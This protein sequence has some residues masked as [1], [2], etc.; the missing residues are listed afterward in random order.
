MATR[1][2][3]VVA[4]DDPV[5]AR[6]Y[7]EA[8][9]HEID[10]LHRKLTRFSPD[11]L[12]SHINR[13]AATRPVK[14]DTEIFALLESA[15]AVKAQS[16]GAFDIALGSGDII[17]DRAARTVAFERPDVSLD[18]GG[19]AKGFAL[20]RAAAI[21]REGGFDRAL[22][23]GGTSSVLA[24]GAPPDAAGWRVAL[25]RSRALPWTELT[26]QALSVSRPFAQL[27]DGGAHIIDPRSR[28]RVLQRR[29]AVAIGPSAAL[30][31]AWSTAISVLGDR[32]PTLGTEWTTSI[33]HEDE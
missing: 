13:T 33:E 24:L 7:L 17:L 14:L 22:L 15:S 2:E 19:I 21:L 25:A 1:F 20:D 31:D 32:P 3:I 9:L 11:S 6:P 26:D 18:L 29:F 8:A 12:L 30:A 23:H 5:G 4:S 10:E 16:G 28:R 27:V